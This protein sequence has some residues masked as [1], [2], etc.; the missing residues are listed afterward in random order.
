MEQKYECQRCGY[1]CNRK[2]VLKR[3]FLRKFPCKSKKIKL[4]TKQLL[5][6]NN[7]R[8]DNNN[9]HYFVPRTKNRTKY[10]QN[11]TKN[12]PNSLQFPPKPLQNPSNSL[13]NPSN[14]L[15][16]P[17][18]S[19]QIPSN[20]LQFPSKIPPKAM[21]THFETYENTLE[22]SINQKCT[23][24]ESKCCPYCFKKF[25][26]MDNLKRHINKRCKIKISQKSSYSDD[27]DDSEDSEDS[28]KTLTLT[29]KEWDHKLEIHKKE[30][31]QQFSNQ[32]EILTQ[33]LTKNYTITQNN[34]HNTDNSHNTNNS[35]NITLN[36]Y[37]SENREYITDKHL[38]YLIKRPGIAIRRLIENI[39]FNPEHPENHNI[40]ATNARSK[41]IQ[42][43]KDKNW[44]FR[45]KKDVI[46]ELIENN[47][48]FLEDHYTKV[49]GN[50]PY[51]KQKKF[52][53]IMNE[54]ESCQ[55]AKKNLEITLLNGTKKV[56]KKK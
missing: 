16:N 47:V 18:N 54:L 50:L 7:I 39:H 23:Y 56:F 42:I 44:L 38:T 52:E 55:D 10:T 37:G 1:K 43:N 20:S 5:K 29:K 41:L 48:T 53:N 49:Q 21:Q 11:R 25:T 6:I 12:T 9:N 2:R 30:L 31:T 13:Q 33:Q 8:I 24:K 26:R 32:I 28:E 14:S 40:K 19:L 36:N 22:S 27:S 15:Q 35:K 4:S 3:H 34:S 46:K 45:D 17:S 51:Y